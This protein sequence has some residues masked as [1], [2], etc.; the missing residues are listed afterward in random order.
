MVFFLIFQKFKTSKIIIHVGKLRHKFLLDRSRGRNERYIYCLIPFL[1]VRKQP[2]TPTTSV[3]VV[4]EN[5][6]DPSFKVR[7]REDETQKSQGRGVSRRVSRA[8]GSPG[9]SGRGGRGRSHVPSP[10]ST[11]YRYVRC[12]VAPA[13]AAP[14]CCCPA[15]A[16]LTH[17]RHA[18]SNSRP[19]ATDNS[20]CLK[21]SSDVYSPR[22]AYTNWKHASRVLRSWIV[23]N[24]SPRADQRLWL[25]CN[26]TRIFLFGRR[27]SR[28]IND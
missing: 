11:V 19:P 10:F 7:P 18:V 27:C 17:W 20:T 15:R 24:Q 23:A 21:G 8:R 13:Q 14:T 22:R 9:G 16:A 2:S 5:S 1:L 25:L 3:G 6:S 28:T 12:N 26:R 4:G